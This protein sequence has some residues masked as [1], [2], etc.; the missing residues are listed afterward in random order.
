MTFKFENYIAVKREKPVGLS[1]THD[2]TINPLY[3]RYFMLSYNLRNNENIVQLKLTS[4]INL[5]TL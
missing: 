2:T 4:L 1:I 5:K 3:I